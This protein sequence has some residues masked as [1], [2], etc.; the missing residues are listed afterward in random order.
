MIVWGPPVEP[1]GEIAGYQV[2]FIGTLSRTRNVSKTPIESY[3][4]VSDSDTNSLGSTIQVQVSIMS[5]LLHACLYNNAAILTTL[6]SQR[7]GQEHLLALDFLA[8]Q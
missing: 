8:A 3:H 2:K 7:L 4:I 5:C 6:L 1:N